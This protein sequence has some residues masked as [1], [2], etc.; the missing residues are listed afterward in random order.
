MTFSVLQET[1]Y[2]SMMKWSQVVSQHFLMFRA[3][4]KTFLWSTNFLFFL[5]APFQEISEPDT[6]WERLLCVET[7]ETSVET[8]RMVMEVVS[9][10][11]PFVSFLP[12]AN[13]VLPFCKTSFKTRLVFNVCDLTSAHVAHK[14]INS[15]V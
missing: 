7:S 9:S 3:L 4:K 6:L 1:L 12:L 13:R 15:A 10:F 5:Q 14:L 2:K 11:A 8:I